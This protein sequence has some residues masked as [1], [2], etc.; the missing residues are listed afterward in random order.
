VL[1]DLTQCGIIIKISKED[2][3]ERDRYM[4]LINPQKLTL[5]FILNKLEHFGAEE[6]PIKNSPEFIKVRE[7]MEQLRADL[8]NSR[9][10]VLL[11]EL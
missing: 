2:E 1:F 3:S 8:V 4:P 10:N 11:K 5:Q 7:K 6:V 9:A